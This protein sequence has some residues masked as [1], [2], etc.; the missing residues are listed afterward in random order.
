MARNRIKASEN[1]AIT[2][3]GF[4]SS[5]TAD[6]RGQFPG[7]PELNG[8]SSAKALEL[9]QEC[10]NGVQDGNV[11]FEMGVNMDYANA[12]AVSTDVIAPSTD[13]TYYN[14]YV[15]N[16]EVPA[17]GNPGDFVKSDFDGHAYAESLRVEQFP[18]GRGGISSQLD[19]STSS[20]AISGVQI[21]DIPG[22]SGPTET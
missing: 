11:D 9:F 12:P 19:P 3:R 20:A 14:P 4:S 2:E 18:L 10:L 1:T 21:A 13:Y 8:Y 6:I 15:P 22:S 7:T 17:T 16:L 5:G